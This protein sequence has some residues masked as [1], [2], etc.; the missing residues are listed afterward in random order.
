MHLGGLLSTQEAR[1]ALGYRLVRLLHFFRAYQPPACIHSS[2]LHAIAFTICQLDLK[3]QRLERTIGLSISVNFKGMVLL[4]MK[5]FIKYCHLVPRMV[6]SM[7]FPRYINLVAHLC[8]LHE[9]A[10]VRRSNKPV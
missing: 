4:M 6:S 1:V 8:T 2:I 3:E 7:V 10:C 5:H 9:M